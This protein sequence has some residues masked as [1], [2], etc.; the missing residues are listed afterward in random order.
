MNVIRI[1]VAMDTTLS[2]AEAKLVEL[3]V[4]SLAAFW[5]NG[6]IPEKPQ[7]ITLP[8]KLPIRSSVLC[9]FRH[10]H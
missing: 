10:I 3:A 7:I 2:D 6:A 8:A 4:L 1:S 9:I 5:R